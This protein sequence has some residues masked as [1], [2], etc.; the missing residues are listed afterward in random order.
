MSFH[1]GIELG[2]VG[3]LEELHIKLKILK[4][5]DKQLGRATNSRQLSIT[6]NWTVAS[7]PVGGAI[8]AQTCFICIC[9]IDCRICIQIIFYE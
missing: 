9:I 1:N 3:H 7:R 8:D 4:L 6:S 2:I 5:S